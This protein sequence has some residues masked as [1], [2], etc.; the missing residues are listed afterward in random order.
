MFDGVNDVCDCS[1]MRNGSVLATAVAVAA[2]P[3]ERIQPLLTPGG[4]R[5]LLDVEHAAAALTIGVEP[6]DALVWMHGEYWYQGEYIFRPCPEGTT[7]TYR[8][9]NISGTPDV[10][11]RLWQRRLIRAQ[12]ADLER[13]AEALPRR[14]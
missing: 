1:P 14:L 4:A 5:M 2:V 7:V 12:Q 6:D 3:F 11:I 10:A 9:R 8:I 13:Y